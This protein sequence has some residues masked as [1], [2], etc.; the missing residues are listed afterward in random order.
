M[1]KL[2]G[3][4]FGSGRNEPVLF[5]GSA[6]IKLARNILHDWTDPCGA[7]LNLA[8]HS[9]TATRTINVGVT[10]ISELALAHLFQALDA[11][12]AGGVTI[13]SI[14]LDFATKTIELAFSRPSSAH[15][16]KGGRT[17][18]AA[19]KT[20][21]IIE[22]TTSEALVPTLVAVGSKRKERADADEKPEWMHRLLARVDR[23]DEDAVLAAMVSIQTWDDGTFGSDFRA[24]LRAVP[25]AYELVV[26]GVREV[27]MTSVPRAYGQVNLDT[28]TITFLVPRSKPLV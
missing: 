19:Q 1:D 17:P 27:S 16:P 10:G 8:F 12:C 13:E 26:S 15:H 6:A 7:P 2:F 5:D 20:G 4:L 22:H 23:D 24:K 9:K 21:P 28:K 14:L 11:V 25:S 18:V 3:K